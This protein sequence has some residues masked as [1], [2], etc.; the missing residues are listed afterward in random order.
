[1]RTTQRTIGPIFTLDWRVTMWQTIFVSCVKDAANW[2]SNGI[3]TRF[4]AWAITPISNWLFFHFDSIQFRL[5][6]CTKK[7]RQLGSCYWRKR[8]NRAIVD[9]LLPLIKLPIKAQYLPNTHPIWILLKFNCWWWISSP[10]IENGAQSR[11][12][13]MIYG[14]VIAV[15]WNFTAVY[16]VRR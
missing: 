8:D 2:L 3:G 7:H 5:F 11:L 6:Q 14:F 16:S 13:L 12:E 1:M 15:L 9:E 10:L 4:A